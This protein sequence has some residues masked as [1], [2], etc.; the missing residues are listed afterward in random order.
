MK[1]LLALLAAAPVAMTLADDPEP[2]GPAALDMPS[3]EEPVRPWR[4]IEDAIPSPEECRDR[5]YQARAAAGQPELE[6]ETADPDEPLLIWAVDRRE[7]GCSVLVVK[8]DPEDIRPVPRPPED[9][10]RLIPAGQ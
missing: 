4:D 7:Q 1:S 6:G 10:P 3:Y 5:I 8:G 2:A 9:A